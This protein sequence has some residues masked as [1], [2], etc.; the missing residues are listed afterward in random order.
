MTEEFQTVTPHAVS[1]MQRLLKVNVVFRREMARGR[2]GAQYMAAV[3]IET[4]LTLDAIEGR[5]TAIKRLVAE[6]TPEWVGETTARRIVTEMVTAGL[7]TADTNAN[8]RRALVI[9][10]TPRLA[11]QSELRW[12]RINES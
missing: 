8:D 2:R 9:T 6:V 5:K 11:R 3:L 10:P 4:R 12:V 1:A 7:V